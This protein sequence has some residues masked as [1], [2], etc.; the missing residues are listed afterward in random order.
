MQY[1]VSRSCRDA[2][3]PVGRSPGGISGLSEHDIKIGE[4]DRFHDVGICI[5]G[6][7]L[8]LCTEC[9]VPPRSVDIYLTEGHS[10]DPSIYI[11]IQPYTEILE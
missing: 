6:E 3:V 4:S 1:A 10:N 8:K 7:Y 9:G 11:Y 5:E 2:T